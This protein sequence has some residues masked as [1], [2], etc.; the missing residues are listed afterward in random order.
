MNLKEA[1]TKISY[2]FN[3]RIGEPITII[4]VFIAMQLI[5]EIVNGVHYLHSLSPP[6]IHR[7]L[8]PSNVFITDGRGGN[9]I[10]I[11]DFGSAT[12]RDYATMLTHDESQLN[13]ELKRVYEYTRGPGTKGYIAPEVR[14]STEYDENCDAYS[15]GCIMMD[16]FCIDKQEDDE[17]WYG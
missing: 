7:D 5:E 14:Y 12:S 1:I 4:G 6:I 16:L 10:K 3:Q 9:Y 17:R 11:G 15:L 2:E 8:K 13:P